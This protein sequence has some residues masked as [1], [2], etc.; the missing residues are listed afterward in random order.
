[1]RD[2]EHNT[3]S[4]IGNE[5]DDDIVGNISSLSDLELFKSCDSHVTWT[6]N[7]KD[8]ELH[9]FTQYSGPRLPDDFDVTTATPKDYFSLFVTP[10]MMETIVQNTN[11]Y[12][13]FVVERKRITQPDYIDKNWT[14]GVDVPEFRAYLGLIYFDGSCSGSNVQKLL[15]YMH[16]SR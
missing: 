2:N 10:D 7:F 9:E 6:Q 5:T 13:E 14:K 1:M 8:I 4:D 3:D 15:E 16:I 12:Q 11:S